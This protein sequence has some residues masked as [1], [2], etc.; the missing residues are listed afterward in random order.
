MSTQTAIAQN[1]E[2]YN[3][4]VLPDLNVVPYGRCLHDRVRAHMYVVTDFHGI[5]VEVA[6]VRLVRW[7]ARRVSTS[8]NTRSAPFNA[9][10]HAS[11][12]D[13]AVPSERYDDSMSRPRSSEVAADYCIAG[14]DGLAAEDDVLR[15][16]D[17][18][19]PGD[20]VACVLPGKTMKS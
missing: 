17:R 5:V 18:G 7:S 2:T 11:F 9:P 12:A 19:T 6:A 1:E 15:A 20:F 14:D 4:T 13:Q 10:H 16:C 8:K 3:H